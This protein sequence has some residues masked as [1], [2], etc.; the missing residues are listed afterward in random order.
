MVHSMSIPDCYTIIVSIY[1]FFLLVIRQHVSAVS[2][3][4]ILKTGDPLSKAIIT[5][6]NQN[7]VDEL[8]RVSRKSI[9]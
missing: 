5:K 4:I 1:Y 3:C 9:P 7:K 8:D 2:D 6:I